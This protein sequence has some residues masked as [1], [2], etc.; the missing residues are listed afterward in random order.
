MVLVL[1]VGITVLTPLL[2]PLLDAVGVSAQGV[3]WGGVTTTLTALALGWLA[4]AHGG[5]AAGLLLAGT[6]L[7][8]TLLPLA[9]PA[10][11]STGTTLVRLA[12]AAGLALGWFWLVGAGDRKPRTLD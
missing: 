3:A 10:G 6:G 11:S 9:S 7:S 2:P 8:G 1:A 12:V 5:L 4:P